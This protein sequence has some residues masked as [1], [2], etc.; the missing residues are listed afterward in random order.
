M[1]NIYIFC[2]VKVIDVLEIPQLVIILFPFVGSSLNQTAEV[3]LPVAL[4]HCNLLCSNTVTIPSYLERRK[5]TIFS[6]IQIG[7][8]LLGGS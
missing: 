5:N 4:R 7:K 8:V 3:L 2:C 6:S 1:K